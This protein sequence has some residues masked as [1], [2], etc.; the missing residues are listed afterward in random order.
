M[1]YKRGEQCIL[2]SWS[3]NKKQINRVKTSLYDKDK[4]FVKLYKESENIEEIYFDENNHPNL[5]LTA[6]FVGKK[7][8]L[9]VQ[10]CIVLRVLLSWY[11]S[12]LLTSGF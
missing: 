5:T 7:E 10:L 6:P 3:Y 12:I 11:M 4:I 8:I 9:I 1:A 2:C